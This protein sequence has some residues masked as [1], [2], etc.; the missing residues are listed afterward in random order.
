M[1]K[2]RSDASWPTTIDV[3]ILDLRLPMLSGLEVYMELDRQ[4]RRLPTI[5]VTAFA[6]E[7]AAMLDKLR[8]LSVTGVLTKPF[9]PAQLLAAVESLA[10][11]EKEVPG[12]EPA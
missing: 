9:D 5:I 8:T 7:E 3:L 10:A 12:P 1:A 2:R 6:R 4:G 11:E